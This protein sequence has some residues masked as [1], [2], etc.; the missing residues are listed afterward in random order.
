M[1][2]FYQ[3]YR[4]KIS[5]FSIFVI[6]LVII[7][8][9]VAY[10]YELYNDSIIKIIKVTDQVEGIKNGPNAEKEC[11]YVQNIIG[12]VMNGAFQGS[13]V[14]FENRYSY[15]RI[16]SDRYQRGMSLFVKLTDSGENLS[17]SVLGEKRDTYVVMLLSFL[18]FLIIAVA[19]TR[20]VTS[21]ISLIINIGVVAGAF[22]MYEKGTNILQLCIAML[23]IFGICSL[24]LANGLNKQTIT[25][26]LASAISIIILYMI[27]KVVLLNTKEPE[28]LM[29][30][31]I[32]GADKLPEI[33]MAGTLIGGFGAILDVAISMTT[34]VNEVIK[35][36]P[37]ITNRELIHSMREIS[38]DVM[39]TMINVLFFTYISGC[40]PMLILRLKNSF[41]IFIILE[42][43][44]TLEIIRFLV[45]SIG[46]V[47]TILIS[48]LISLLA[49][50]K[51]GV[52]SD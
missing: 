31:Y 17:V 3:K 33:F 44:L 21:L 37:D 52:G 11:Y 43:Y 15:S 16:T 1:N 46:I 6:V 20:G 34:S 35:K 2:K 25:A 30:N 4:R 5:V 28:Y 24:L 10:D 40:M 13:V 9:F 27:Y 39:G 32:S 45:G 7:N 19:G 38:Y 12:K 36:T 47:L 8:V 48:G 22:Y 50:R 18:I 29:Q 41:S 42:L 26:I 14:E 49:Y 23:I 51:K